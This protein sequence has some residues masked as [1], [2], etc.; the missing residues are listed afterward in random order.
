[1]QLASFASLAPKAGYP[2]R[3]RTHHF[4]RLAKEKIILSNQESFRTAGFL[5]KMHE[6]LSR[7]ANLC[8]HERD[9]TICDSMQ[10]FSG[11]Q[12]IVRYQGKRIKGKIINVVEQMKA[13]YIS[14]EGY[15]SCYDEYQAFE[16]LRTPMTGDFSVGVNMGCVKEGSVVLNRWGENGEVSNFILCKRPFDICIRTNSQRFSVR[17][18]GISCGCFAYQIWYI[19]FG[20]AHVRST[21]D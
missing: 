6:V 17:S 14:F 21:S 9:F 16:C 20:C 11:A 18:A 3:S 13:A 12:I 4:S 2:F 10:L 1:V 7:L 8:P 15:G 19:L 5:P